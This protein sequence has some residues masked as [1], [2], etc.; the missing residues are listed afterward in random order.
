MVGDLGFGDLGPRA[1]VEV[2]SAP[3]SACRRAIRAAGAPAWPRIQALLVA[4]QDVTP[5]TRHGLDAVAYCR[6]RAT[7]GFL[8]LETPLTNVDDAHITRNYRWWTAAGARGSM[9]DDGLTFGTNARAGVCIHFRDKVPSPIRRS[10]HSAL[11]VTV[12]DLEG[13]QKV[14]SRP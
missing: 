8:R 4:R 2:G 6:L 1:P 12:E 5:R 3:R 13:L 11:T 9:K 14:L 7:F 10:G